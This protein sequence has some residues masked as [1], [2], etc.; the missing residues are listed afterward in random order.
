MEM[1]FQNENENDFQS[2]IENAFQSENEKR[3]SK[4]KFTFKIKMKTNLK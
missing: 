3:F 2:E 4:W 1:N